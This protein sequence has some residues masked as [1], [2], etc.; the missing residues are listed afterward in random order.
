[1]VFLSRILSPEDRAKRITQ[2]LEPN[3]IDK[4]AGQMIYDNTVSVVQK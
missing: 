2:L 1:M 3:Q 4:A